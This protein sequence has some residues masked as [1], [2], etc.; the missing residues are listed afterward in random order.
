MASIPDEEAKTE[1]PGDRSSS[2]ESPP[3][4]DH[5]GQKKTHPDAVDPIL[6]PAHE[7]WLIFMIC[8]AQFLSLAGLAQTIAPLGIIGRSFDV[9]D[10]GELSWYPAAFS[11]TLGTFILPAGR[12]V[13]LPASNSVRMMRTR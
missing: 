4:P 11:L 9:I 8:M 1:T 5:D 10:E 7:I 2:S 3:A 12:L 6:S 13:R